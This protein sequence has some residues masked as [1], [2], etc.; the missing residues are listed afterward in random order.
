M[1]P[2][3]QYRIKEKDRSKRLIFLKIAF[4]FSVMIL[5]IVAR[6]LVGSHEEFKKGE[7]ALLDGKYRRAIVFYERAIRYYFPLNP[8]V[9]RSIERIWQI[10]AEAK[11]MDEDWLVMEALR[12]LKGSLYATQHTVA[13]NYTLIRKVEGEMKVLGTP[14]P[15]E[16]ERGFPSDP[17]WSLLALFG[18]FCWSGCMVAFI[19][20]GHERIN[21]RNGTIIWAWFAIIG[22]GYILW[23]WGM[24]RA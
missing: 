15:P 22:F 3:L 21:Q 9:S 17:S 5:L 24:I 13:H 18:F 6:V 2:H 8:Y 19:L 4:F 20:H 14:T 11:K 16:M 23:L 7:K 12:S 10:A 1:R